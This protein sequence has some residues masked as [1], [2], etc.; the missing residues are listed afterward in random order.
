MSAFDALRYRVGNL[1]R[2]LFDR[3]AYRRELDTELRHHLEL[4]A[5]QRRHGG[6]SDDE[7]RRAARTRFGNPQRVRE[8]LVDSTG[9]SAIDALSQDVR[10]AWRTLR[11][12]PGF[13]L[14]AVAT[15]AIGIGA[16]TAIFS[17]V[18]ALLVR[19]LPFPAPNELMQVGSDGRAVEG[20]GARPDGIWS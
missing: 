4:D 18:N 2:A 8:R 17:A 7:A 5:M 16:N 11:A 13:A 12:S 1:R 10:F 19:P 9:V 14:V 3:D 20:R 15:L 6:A